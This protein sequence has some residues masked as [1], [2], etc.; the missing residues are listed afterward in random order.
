MVTFWINQDFSFDVIKGGFMFG[1][2][3]DNLP[4]YLSL[5]GDFIHRT[6]KI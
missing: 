6:S 4:N 1:V 2:L 5:S 3:E